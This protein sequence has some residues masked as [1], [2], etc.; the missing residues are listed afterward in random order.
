MRATDATMLVPSPAW[1][2]PRVHLL[3]DTWLLTIFA[4]LLASAVPWLVNGLDV[5][6]AAAAAGL[7]ALAGLHLAFTAL[8]NPAR[9]H[10]AWHTPALAALHAAGIAVVTFVWMQAGG[11]QNPAFLLVFALPVVGSIFLARWQP[12]L[13]AGIAIVAVVGAALAQAP[14]LRWYAA[15]LGPAGGWLAA[16]FGGERGAS[17]AP[18]PGFYA[19]SSYFV[20][21][22]EVFAIF[23]AACAIAGEYL[24]TV[25]DR[26]HGHVFAARAEAERGHELWATLIEHLPLPALL[27]DSDGLQVIYAS[28]LVRSEFAD[29]RQDLAGSTLVEAV[30]F[31]YPEMVQALIGGA[32]GVAP[33][34]TVRVGGRLRVC[35]VRVQH[36][37]Q[38]GRRFALVILQ[39]RTPE[40]CLKAALDAAGQAALVVDAGGKVLAF[41][42]PAQGLF[43]GTRIDADAAQLLAA[44][45]AAARWWEP[46]LLGRRKMHVEVLQRL[47]QVT[48]TA[49]PVPGEDEHVF[50]V[51]FLPI[52]RAA[53]S[54]QAA[55]AAT[56]V[57]PTLTSTTVVQPQ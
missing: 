24:G 50:V 49:V 40:F 1:R 51:S 15:G 57:V 27:V 28:E 32:G 38:R 9:A 44:P 13:M 29:G 25:F 34:A 16:M 31:T 56:V 37:A 17:D 41:N 43:A 20:V 55:A 33:L 30:Q 10:H 7:L 3:D 21:L 35:E 47:Y 11:L 53:I 14:E 18:F 48:S 5:D 22:L 2:D 46:S 36:V 54:Q 12:Y 39:D 4:I 19:P 23:L 8:V 52:A 26:L 45:D 6:F 42:K